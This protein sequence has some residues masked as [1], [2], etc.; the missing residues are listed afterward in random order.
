MSERRHKIIEG[1]K[2][3]MHGKYIQGHEKL[4]YIGA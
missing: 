4:G 3:Q 1:T 2:A